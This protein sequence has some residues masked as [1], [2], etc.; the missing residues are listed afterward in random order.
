MTSF[1]RHVRPGPAVN[2]IPMAL[3]F[4]LLGLVIWRNSDKVGELLRHRLDLRV[5]GVGLLIYQISLLITFARWY[6]LVRV[7]EPWFKLRATLLLGFIGNFFSLVIPGPAGGDFIKAAYLLRMRI[8]QT[9]AVASMLI[10]RILGLLGLFVLAAG[11]GGLAWG[12]ATPEVRRLIVAAWVAL[13]LGL[14]LLAAIF[15]R[16]PTRLFPGLGG[17]GHGRLS[18]I[19]FELDALSTTYRLHLDVVL[20]GLGLSVI[21]H[22]LNVLAF[23]LMGR[24]LFPT[25][26]TTTLVQHYLMVPLTLFSTVVPLPFGALGLSEGVGDQLLR[27]VG[28]PSGAL[29]MMGFRVLNYG[30]GLIAAGVYLAN[31]REVRALTK[32]ATDRNDEQRG[33]ESDRAR[34]GSS[35]GSRKSHLREDIR[36]VAKSDLCC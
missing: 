12:V 14:L 10:D 31:L 28:H 21:G 17:E 24:M 20:A 1:P 5:L 16:V 35:A 13:G 26:M 19:I 30:C 15:A 22:T 6:L 34:T 33:G 9:Q 32:A 2:A 3:A 18:R 29:A 36:R 8:K 4:T 23:F 25:G 11:A 27:Q 7:I